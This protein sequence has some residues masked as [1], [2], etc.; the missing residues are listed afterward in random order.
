MLERMLARVPEY[1]AGLGP[2]L[3]PVVR[4][5]TVAGNESAHGLLL[6]HGFAQDRWSFLMQVDLPGEA[7]DSGEVEPDLPD[8]Y[9]LST[10]EEVEPEEMR[11]AHNLAFGGFHPGFTLWDEAMWTQFVTSAH[12]YRPALSLVARGEDGAIAAYVQVAE[13]AGVADATGI[14]EA[15]VAKVGTTPDHR[16]RGLGTTL[17]RIAM[18]R[19]ARAGLRRATL[20]V[21]AENPSGALGV[22]ERAGFR[23]VLE[24]RHYVLVE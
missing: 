10:W 13:H 11:A 8:G 17:L 5:F 20:E 23:T 7:D 6:D 16:R 21:E 18:L 9:V 22:Y 3:R 14:R 15:F 24:Y 12:A 2:G 1:V 19:S 4:G